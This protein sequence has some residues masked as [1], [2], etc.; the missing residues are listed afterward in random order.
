MP[1][2]L[3]EYRGVAVFIEQSRGKIASAAFELLGEGRKLADKLGV[4]LSGILLG[5]EIRPLSAEIIAR[6]AD[7]VYLTDDPQLKNYTTDGYL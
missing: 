7:A 1:S 2:N 3:D 6:G 4:P 5:N